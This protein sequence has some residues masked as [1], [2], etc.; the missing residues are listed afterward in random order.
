MFVVGAYDLSLEIFRGEAGEIAL[1]QRAKVLTLLWAYNF[2][3]GYLEVRISLSHT[4][5][6]FNP[7]H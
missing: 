5:L 2:L 6:S 1:S 3:D 7:S 4:L